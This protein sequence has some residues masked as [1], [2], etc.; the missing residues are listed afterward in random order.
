MSDP[1]RRLSISQFRLLLPD[2]SALTRTIDSVHLHHTWK[3]SRGE[4]HGLETIEAMRRFHLSLGW[5]DIA[6]HVTIDPEGGVWTGRNWNQPP[7]SVRGHN[8]SVASGPFMIEI[9]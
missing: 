1:I 2:V 7:A 3:P 8:G 9:D 4:F 6:Q 5:A